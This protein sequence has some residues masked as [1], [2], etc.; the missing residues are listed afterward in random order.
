[1]ELEL[2][3]AAAPEMA[4]GTLAGGGLHSVVMSHSSRANFD[5]KRRVAVASALVAAALV[6]CAVV[7]TST[8]GRTEVSPPIHISSSSF[9]SFPHLVPEQQDLALTCRD[10][11]QVCTSMPSQKNSVR[12]EFLA[13]PRSVGAVQ[14][15]K[16]TRAATGQ[17]AAAA[18]PSRIS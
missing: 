16:E 10:V 2:A 3:L 4:Q 1:M 12:E 13:A 9:A 5:R 18:E 17:P 15:R 8:S 11:A 7:S 14:A 6:A